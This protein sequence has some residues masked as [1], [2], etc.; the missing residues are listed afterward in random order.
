MDKE[1]A[2]AARCLGAADVLFNCADLFTMAPCLKSAMIAGGRGSIVKI[3][4]VVDSEKGVPNRF[5]YG[6]TKSAVVGL[7]KPV[8]ADYVG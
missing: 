2:E 8:A 4:S 6:A 3:S 1:I 5:V 7:T